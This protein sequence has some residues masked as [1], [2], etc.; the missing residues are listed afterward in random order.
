MPQ[1][2]LMNGKDPMF[3]LRRGSGKGALLNYSDVPLLRYLF[4]TGAL[5]SLGGS[6][7]GLVSGPSIGVVCLEAIGALFVCAVAIGAPVLGWIERHRGRNRLTEDE[8]A[9]D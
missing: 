1:A 3:R 8:P 7:V 4:F 9:H 2:P 6:L 5:L